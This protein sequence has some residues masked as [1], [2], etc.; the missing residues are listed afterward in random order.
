MASPYRVCV[1]CSGNICRSPMAEYVLRQ[2]FD[3]AGLGDG[4]A[5]D[6]AGTGAW[7]LGDGADPRALA[8][9]HAA[10]YDGNAHRAR[11]IEA[12]WLGERDLVLCADD[13]HFRAVQ[14]LARGHDADVRMVR[15]F[16]PEA[17]DD[18][19]LADPYYGSHDD[20]T[21]CLRQIRRSSDGIVEHV[22]AE[23]GA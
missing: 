20:F 3:D 15:E 11:R 10:G 5:V 13:G 9:L 19:D 16:D 8:A 4:V 22:R 14:R 1:V 2:A 18:L 23:L 17:G 7:H 12:H 6:S 21:E